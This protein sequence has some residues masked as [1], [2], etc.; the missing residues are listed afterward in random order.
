MK[1]VIKRLGSSLVLLVFFSIAGHA[2]TYDLSVLQSA[3]LRAKSL[4]TRTA[5]LDLINTYEESLR[6]GQLHKDS[7][8]ALNYALMKA[9]RGD[10]DG[11]LRLTK[12]LVDDEENI[13]GLNMDV[14]TIQSI[15]TQLERNIRIL[16]SDLDLDAL[17]HKMHKVKVYAKL[18]AK[19]T[20]RS[21]FNLFGKNSK[22]GNVTYRIN[23]M[24]LKEIIRINSNGELNLGIDPLEAEVR[25]IE[26]VARS[27]N[28]SKSFDLFSP[29]GLRRQSNSSYSS[30]K[31]NSMIYIP[32]RAT[33]GLVRLSESSDYDNSSFDG[34]MFRSRK[35]ITKAVHDIQQAV[36]SAEAQALQNLLIG[37]NDQ[38]RK[39][40]KEYGDTRQATFQVFEVSFD[41]WEYEDV[42]DQAVLSYF[43]QQ[44]EYTKKELVN[45][46]KSAKKN[47]SFLMQ[48]LKN[49]IESAY[50]RVHE[51]SVFRRYSTSN[52]ALSGLF[53]TY[54]M[55]LNKPILDQKNRDLLK[56][57]FNLIA[58]RVQSMESVFVQTLAKVSKSNEKNIADMLI[59]SR[60]AETLNSD[61]FVA[62]EISK[63][64]GYSSFQAKKRI[65]N[66]QEKAENPF[67]E[68]LQVL[69]AMYEDGRRHLVEEILREIS[70]ERGEENRR[71]IARLDD[72]FKQLQIS[73]GSLDLAKYYLRADIENQF[74][75][76][77]K[78]LTQ[79]QIVLEDEFRQYSSIPQILVGQSLLQKTKQYNT[80]LKQLVNT[81]YKWKKLGKPKAQFDVDPFDER[82]PRFI[83]MVYP[84]AERF[85]S[86]V[87]VQASDML[88]QNPAAVSMQSIK[89]FQLSFNSQMVIQLMDNRD[90]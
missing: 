87:L 44:L 73:I 32:I 37:R 66:I 75:D 49:H 34:F 46:K 11:A 61:D 63:I 47:Y 45:L 72:N 68:I 21:K 35:R 14:Q 16:N 13:E 78:G 36:R 39:I 86:S 90:F 26:R 23:L 54:N 9:W 76:I 40:Q 57:S 81:K 58:G 25:I 43:K 83:G 3:L 52:Q 18:S 15:H 82:E 12:A 27:S 62:K 28:K 33:D 85:Y 29:N 56:L 74:E 77:R 80:T 84:E 24:D 88:G 2:A 50:S 1:N 20:T 65:E 59:K 79:V 60:R 51:G 6:G 69:M 38:L 48:E 17:F 8:G 67:T 5:V 42:N 31:V 19:Y 4:E 55:F 7:E 41:G 30:S 10:F 22:S 89:D 71:V 64:A 53:H 70:L